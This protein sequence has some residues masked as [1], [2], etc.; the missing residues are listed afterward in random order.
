MRRQQRANYADRIDRAVRLIEDRTS[1]G[2]AP[3]LA[4]LAEVA[5]LSEYHFHRMFRLMT[6]ESPAAAVTRIRLGHSLPALA[7]RG[8]G[9]ATERSGYATSQAYARALRASAG[10]SPGELR[11]DG[12]LRAEVAASLARPGRAGAESEPPPL[13]IEVVSFE[14]LRLLT[15]RNVGA[16][17]ELNSGY[18]KLFELLMEQLGPES[19]E[20]IYGLPDDD[21]RD[22]APEDCRFTCA[23]ATGAAGGARGELVERTL[24]G[25]RHA[26]MHWR[27][28]FDRIHNAI[29]ALYLWA[30][31]AKEEIGA[32]PL[33]I[34][35]RDDPDEVPPED[36]RAVVYLPLRNG[37]ES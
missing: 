25:G 14:P 22:T 23:L 18:G 20:G 28:D 31:D 3:D 4:E 7:D 30:L 17:E 12:D 24:A 6:G 37:D 5:A 35:Y 11:T 13:S 29:D 19:I 36:Q 16:Y 9:A 33:F 26:A 21:P 2:E 1:A 34:H 15:L 27:G 8:I 32:A 10:A